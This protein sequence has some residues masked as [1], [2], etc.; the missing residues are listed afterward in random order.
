MRTKVLAKKI[1]AALSLCT[2]GLVGNAQAVG[3]VVIEPDAIQLV[4]IRIDGGDGI[5]V[6]AAD[7]RVYIAADTG[8]ISSDA[9]TTL[10]TGNTVYD[11][12][13]Q[14]KVAIGK[15]S[16]AAGSSSIAL[17]NSS[18]ANSDNSISIG[19]SSVAADANQGIAIGRYARVEKGATSAV[20][21]GGSAAEE[22]CAY[23]YGVSSIALGDSSYAGGAYSISIGDSYVDPKA[24]Q[25]VAIGRNARVEAGATNAVAIGGNDGTESAAGLFGAKASGVSSVAIGDSSKSYGKG[26]VALG[27]SSQAGTIEKNANDIYATALGYG[28]RAY[29]VDS[30]SIG[31]SYVDPKAGQ[32]IA[33][34]KNASIL[35]G[36]TNAV[37]I[38]GNSENTTTAF[39][40]TAWGVSSV[41]IGDTSKSYGKG[42]VAL[43]LSS[44][45]GTY[46]TNSKDVYATAL[47]YSSEA[48]AFYSISIGDS[49]VGESANQGIAIGRNASLGDGATN[50]VAIGGNAG[51]FLG[52][53]AYAE[54]KSSV[55][56]GD[57]SQTYGKGSVAL[58]LYSVA[59]TKNKYIDKFDKGVYA[60]ALGYSSQAGALYS[61]SIGDS[62]VDS[63]AYQGIAIGRYA[64]VAAGATNAVAIGGNELEG[65]GAYAF[66]TSAVAIGDTAKSYGKGSV[67]LGY[68]T[69]AGTSAITDS[70]TEVYATALGYFAYAQAPNSIAIGDA[71]VSDYA[72]QGI[73]IGKYSKALET[74]SVA[75]G[76][77][78]D[79]G[80]SAQAHGVSSVALGDN[81]NAYGKGS[82]ALGLA[83]HAGNNSV[84]AD[85]DMYAIALGYYSWAE[86]PNSIAIGDCYV[87]KNANQGIAIGKY[88]KVLA[89]NAVAIGG[90]DTE[91]SGAYAFGTSAVALGDSSK[92]YG[93]GSMALGYGAQAGTEEMITTLIDEKAIGDAD[94]NVYATAIGYDAKAEGNSS[95]AVGNS[96]AFGAGS[97]AVGKGNIAKGLSSVAI[98]RANFVLGNSVTVTDEAS[99]VTTISG[100]NTAMGIFNVV[101]GEGSGAFGYQNTVGDEDTKYDYSYAVGYDNEVTN[102][103]NVVFGTENTISGSATIAIGKK[104]QTS[105]QNAIVIGGGTDSEITAVA[106]NS[107]VLG[108]GST[109]E[110][111]DTVSVGNT[112]SQRRIVHVAA[113]KADTDAVNVGQLKSAI[114]G[115]TYVGSDT[116]EVTQKT[117]EGSVT[118]QNVIQIRNMAIGEDDSN[119]TGDVTAGKASIAL[120]Q[121]SSAAD[122]WSVALGSAAN[123]SAR[124]VALGSY[125]Q[126]EGT[127][128]IAIGN[129][130][131]VS[132]NTY[133]SMALGSYAK[134]TVDNSVAIGSDSVATES[135]TDEEIKNETSNA[136]DSKTR[137]VS[138]G[139]TAS[140]IYDEETGGTYGT[141]LLSRLTNVAVGVSNTDAATY[142]Q[143][144]QNKNYDFVTANDGSGT[145]KVT[146]LDN[147]GKTAFTLT[148]DG[149]GADSGSDDSGSGSGGSD[150]S[151][152]G[153]SGG[154]S[155]GSGSTSGVTY[156]AG[157]HI[158]ISDS[159]VISATADG[160]V[161]EGNTGL[162][163]GGAIYKKTGDTTKLSEAGLPDN[164]TDSVLTVNDRLSGFRN[165]INKVGA[166]AAALA[167]LHPEEFDPNDK[168]SFSVGYGHYK[169]ANAGAIGAFYKP[170]QD[171]TVSLGSTFGNGNPMVNLG[172]SFKLGRRGTSLGVY[173]SNAELVREIQS[174]R[175]GNERQGA[176]IREQAEKIASQEKKIEAL[177]EKLDAL[178]KKVE[179]S[180]AVQKT[181]PAR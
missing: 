132:D 109:S 40:A 80:N 22:T 166:G 23:A 127:A 168:I 180:E 129:Y 3:G 119:I 113:G 104:I 123:A 92:A 85:G 18:G 141:T 138:F 57:T 120:G 164:L 130:S 134:A 98:G 149:C 43:G 27:L 20:A 153:T 86:A 45:A 150:G 102:S 37:A 7:Y 154:S 162:V 145:K 83:S 49:A 140:D 161:E 66:G 170:N 89:I 124:S 78:K 100:N 110:E 93:K 103:R 69:R 50:A 125:A 6:T 67:A 24:G 118:K 52:T 179:L 2:L 91:G 163:T 10:V 143:L 159:H 111:A 75:I 172:F 12:L 36:A 25:G 160:K 96:Y 133:G 144:V 70:S 65:S 131:R 108:Y 5:R 105:A 11:Y 177:E 46:S 17:G 26:S 51:T 55:S 79:E 88:T 90:N 41:A 4:G 176:F 8:D 29:A 101:F 175:A 76:G 114:A 122:G 68:M 31:D 39:A 155:S 48:K 171:T 56:I 178:L 115:N 53:G 44:V 14:E 148:L 112:T 137:T 38:G 87:D 34:G 42:S 21:I 59:G 173:S 72:N 106:D 117:V 9:T 19:D 142:G 47:G 63:N 156:T 30:I 33:I 181:I 32:G 157:D 13:H 174:L 135:R 128:G 139:H 15:D 64:T 77:N 146:I 58:G 121:G 95:T 82:V 74:N 1:L 169:N 136:V 73:A 151:G 28:S 158:S 16:N 84:A 81:S 54:G 35:S 107:V 167:A 61:I 116:V 147:N 71:W 94:T 97:T 62:A 152:S 126:S 165:D 99:Q 60:T